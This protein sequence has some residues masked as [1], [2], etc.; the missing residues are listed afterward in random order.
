M[1]GQVMR[2]GQWS[3]HDDAIL[4]AEDGS[5]SNGLQ[6]L[7]ASARYSVPFRTSLMVWGPPM[8]PPQLPAPGA[9]STT[10]AF[11][12]LLLKKAGHDGP[13]FLE[14]HW[15]AGRVTVQTLQAAV[16]QVW[17]A[18]DYPNRK[19]PEAIWRELFTTAGYTCAGASAVRPTAALRLYRGCVPA[20]RRGWSWSENRAVAEAFAS[21]N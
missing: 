1:C 21:G 13:H 14:H 6:R 10:E 2:A 20:A 16:G 8:P 12:D 4:L 11:L 9:H 7:T 17:S 5:V 19:L 15:K 18:S 3:P